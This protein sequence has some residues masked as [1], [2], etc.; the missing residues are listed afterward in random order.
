MRHKLFRKLVNLDSQPQEARKR[1]DRKKVRGKVRA[2]DERIGF[3]I[4]CAN[5]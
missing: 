5:F 3:S 1:Q 4:Y 2:E